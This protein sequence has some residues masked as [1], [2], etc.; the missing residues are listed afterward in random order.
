MENQSLAMFGILTMAAFGGVILVVAIYRRQQKQGMNILQNLAMVL[1]GRMERKC[2]LA[3]HEGVPY[4]VQF[5]KPGRGPVLVVISIPG[6]TGL[7]FACRKRNILD[8][9]G[10]K[11]GLVPRIEIPD[12]DFARDHYI[13]SRDPHKAAQFLMNMHTTHGIRKILETRQEMLRMDANGISLVFP[14]ES[15]SEKHLKMLSPPFIREKVSR[16]AGI[17]GPE[18]GLQAKISSVAN[19]VPAS[20]LFFDR[21]QSMIP[22]L[23]ITIFVL[24]TL[25]F[26]ILTQE[27]YLPTNGVALVAGSF[28]FAILPTIAGTVLLFVLARLYFRKAPE[29]HR[30]FLLSICMVPVV[31]FLL[32]TSFFMWTNGALD[33]GSPAVHTARVL[34]KTIHRSKSITYRLRLTSWDNDEIPISIRVPK[35]VFDLFE[36]GDRAVLSTKPGRWGYEWIASPPE[37]AN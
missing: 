14:L 28:H 26:M 37:P 19:I 17:A 35:T 25:I 8:T 27:K 20:G 31:L 22:V 15:M 29:G 13:F 34:E 10:Q 2:L 5:V 32:F 18:R 30:L 33:A 16:L 11:L 12:A 7:F 9:I 23:L 1:D 36:Q 24:A 6:D 4:Q 21:K 3:M